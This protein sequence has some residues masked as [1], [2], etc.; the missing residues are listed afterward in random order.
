MNVHRWDWERWE[1]EQECDG[2]SEWKRDEDGDADA[3][4]KREWERDDERGSE[5]AVHEGL[6]RVS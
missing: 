3:D 4:G 6:G 5:E 1:R 2:E